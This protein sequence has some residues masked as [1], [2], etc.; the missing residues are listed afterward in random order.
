MRGG[1]GQQAVN[2]SIPISEIEIRLQTREGEQR[3]LLPG[4][5]ITSQPL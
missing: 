2:H 1:E 5:I 3:Q 4:L